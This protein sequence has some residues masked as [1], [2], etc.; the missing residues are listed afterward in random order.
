MNFLYKKEPNPPPWGRSWA[1][2]KGSWAARSA[3]FRENSKWWTKIHTPLTWVSR[4]WRSFN[5]FIGSLHFLVDWAQ[6]VSQRWLR[7]K[8]AQKCL[9]IL[10]LLCN[11]HILASDQ[12]TF[13][14]Y[15]ATFEQLSLQKATFD[16]PLSNFW[17]LNFLRNYGKLFSPL[18]PPFSL[19]WGTVV[20]KYVNLWLLLPLIMY[21]C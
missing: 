9:E 1:Q 17:T 15:R 6:V 7:R 16:C 5:N 4:R 11:L 12:K 14:F 13:L 19:V 2:D 10:L 21:Y 20:V 18:F 8:I 3:I